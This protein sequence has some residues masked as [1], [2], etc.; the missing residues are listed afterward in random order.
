M[1][2]NL[3]V[4]NFDLSIPEVIFGVGTSEKLATQAKKIKAK[5][6]IFI[7]DKGIAKTGLLAPMKASLEKNVI[8]VG[9]FDEI[10]QEPSIKNAE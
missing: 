5:R 3:A 7:T 8:E 10:E 6:A 4:Q 2:K 9:I 1:V